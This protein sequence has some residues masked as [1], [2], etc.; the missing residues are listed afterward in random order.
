MNAASFN[1]DNVKQI[2]SQFLK[3]RCG[4]PLLELKYLHIHFNEPFINIHTKFQRQVPFESLKR[5]ARSRKAVLEGLQK[6]LACIALPDDSTGEGITTEAALSKLREAKEALLA[7]KEQA[8]LFHI[9][10]SIRQAYS[11]R[12]QCNLHKFLSR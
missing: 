11:E 2:D 12:R 5:E 9:P 3:V 6:A 7:L 4:G 10:R 1:L 8:R